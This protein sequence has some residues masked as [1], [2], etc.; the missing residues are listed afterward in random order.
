MESPNPRTDNSHR[1]PGASNSPT[2]RRKWVNYV[3]IL[4]LLTFLTIQ[5]AASTIM[6]L[7]LNRVIELGYC[8][9]YYQ[10]HN[11][12]LIGPG[13]EVEEGL[14]KVTEVQ[15]NLAKLYGGINAFHV[16]CGEWIPHKS[17]ANI[18]R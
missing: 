1:S 15:Q 11:P 17:S 14:C 2:Q 12:S 5:S 9:D 8:R 18:K 4:A 3:P 16:L 7:P 13:G 10:E 6:N